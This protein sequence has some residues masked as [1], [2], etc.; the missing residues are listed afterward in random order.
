MLSHLATPRWPILRPEC[1]STG[2]TNRERSLASP[3]H[4]HARP[5]SKKRRLRSRNSGSKS[6]SQLYKVS[7]D[8]SKNGESSEN[9]LNSEKSR[10]RRS[11]EGDKPKT[12]KNGESS[13]ER[14]KNAGK[15]NERKIVSESCKR[16]SSD[17]NLLG[18]NCR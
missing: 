7:C 14:K 17:D 10:K 16:R 4:Q 12:K 18:V 2:S 8:Q 9:A 13:A 3:V 11:D 1:C 6:R 15:K 5:S